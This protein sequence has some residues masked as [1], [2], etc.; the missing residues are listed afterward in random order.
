[1]TFSNIL[2]IQRYAY[3]NIFRISYESN[4]LNFH[5]TTTDKNKK[6][7]N[8]LKNQLCLNHKTIGSD[9]KNETVNKNKKIKMINKE[10]KPKID[11]ATL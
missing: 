9:L 5:T 2:G 8:Y 3:G 4:S 6:G 1:M 7:I 10:N 11:Q